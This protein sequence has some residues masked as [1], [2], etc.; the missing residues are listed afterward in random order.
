[1]DP[2]V[3]RA[4]GASLWVWIAASA[5]ALW[6]ILSPRRVEPAPGRAVSR[7]TAAG[8]GVALAL[9][10]ILVTSATASADIIVPPRART[11]FVIANV[12]DHPDHVVLGLTRD[13]CTR[14]A[15]STF[16][17][18]SNKRVCV[19]PDTEQ[20]FY[21]IP[22]AAFRPEDLET[23]K[24]AF[25]EGNG[26]LAASSTT[27]TWPWRV[28]NA[29]YPDILDVLSIVSIDAT[30]FRVRKIKVVYT[31]P[32]GGTEELQYDGQDERPAPRG[33]PGEW[34]GADAAHGSLMLADIVTPGGTFVPGFAVAVMVVAGILLAAILVRRRRRRSS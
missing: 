13:A 30:D 18:T 11:C 33:I 32:G 20:V 31:H 34:G 6:W 16:V 9:A 3:G 4:A 22:R 29:Q 5:A 10:A 24:T 26:D 28:K 19:Q 21:A 15:I 2:Q 14:R 8:A 27:L 17:V 23:R 7:Q 12:Q 1:V 25:F